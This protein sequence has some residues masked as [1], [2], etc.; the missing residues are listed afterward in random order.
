MDLR[1]TYLNLPLSS[2][3]VPSASPLSQE[4]GNL[5]AMEDAGAGAVVLHSLFEEQIEQEERSLGYYLMQGTESYAEALS[6]FPT[7]HEFRFG[8]DE[9]LEHLRRAKSALGIPVIASLNGTTPGGWL[10][11]A[12]RMQDAGADALELNLYGV[13]ADPDIV[14]Q[15]VE[16]RLLE[17]V[18][19][20]RREIRIP[21]AIKIG[22]YFTAPASLAARLRRAGADGLVLFNRFYQPDIDLEALEVRPA[23][24][25]S[26]P[27]ELRLRLRWIAILHGRLPLSLAATGG[28]ATHEDV[29]KA[30]MAGA[31]VAMLCSVLLRRGVGHLA[32]IRADLVR[33][34]EEHEYASIEQMKGSMSH[35]TSQDPG[36][37]ERAS[38]VKAITGYHL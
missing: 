17:V 22:P 33:W 16:A 30:I 9:Y 34:M 20:V 31:D 26:H 5:K 37:F 23:V 2:P 1:T 14:P 27:D 19:L 8:P 35:R 38:Y 24:S 15:D 36:A 10:L 28:I 11:Y 12:R 29:L 18:A 3:L 25:L 7:A 32:A 13:P 4:I 6:Y 21:L